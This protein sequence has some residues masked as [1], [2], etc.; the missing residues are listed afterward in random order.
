MLTPCGAS[1]LSPESVAELA[2]ALKKHSPLLP[3]AFKKV[4]TLTN[5]NEYAGSSPETNAFP[6]NYIAGFLREN[7]VAHKSV[8]KGLTEADKLRNP[9][10][11]GLCLHFGASQSNQNKSG[12]SPLRES[13]AAA[14]ITKR[15]VL[16]QPGSAEL[17]KS[18]LL[19]PAPKDQTDPILIP[20][21]SNSK[22]RK[23][24]GR[25]LEDEYEDGIQDQS[26]LRNPIHPQIEDRVN[27]VFNM[28]FHS[29]SSNALNDS[30]CEV[31]MSPKSSGVQNGRLD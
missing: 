24:F 10:G 23:R 4:D 13:E 8:P 26:L 17:F 18:E 1:F 15:R 31:K 16:Y 14:S 30:Y 29:F 19:Y 20:K 2:A 3:L 28:S 9:L 27:P 11:S 7:K 6:K 25:R 21:Q 5:L 12:C 22:P